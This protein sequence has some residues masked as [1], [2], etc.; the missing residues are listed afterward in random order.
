MSNCLNIICG[1]VLAI[2]GD[3]QGGK[4]WH[5]ATLTP[6]TPDGSATL[7][8]TVKLSNSQTIKLSN[9]PIANPH[10]TTLLHSPL[11]PLRPPRLCVPFSHLL[12][13]PNAEARRIVQAM[14]TTTP[15]YS[16]C[17][18]SLYPPC[19]AEGYSASV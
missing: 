2:D 14:I 13:S 7:I 18:R 8:S 11:R 3:A 4:A 19:F 12:L 16:P 6:A 15:E 5:L 10:N 1:D 9:Y 17:L